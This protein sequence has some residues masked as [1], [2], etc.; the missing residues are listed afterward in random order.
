MNTF[1]RV[2]QGRRS[3]VEPHSLPKPVEQSSATPELIDLPPIKD[4]AG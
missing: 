2:V 3:G 4:I 1:N